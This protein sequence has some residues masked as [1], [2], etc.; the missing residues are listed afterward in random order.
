MQQKMVCTSITPSIGAEVSGLDCSNVDPDNKETLRQ[1]LISRKVLVFR[2]QIISALEFLEFMKIFGFPY[3]E[4]LEPQDGN[5]AEV[6]VIKIKPNERQIINFWHMDYS[7]LEKPASVL[8]LYAEKIP[9][10]GGDTL[11]TNLEAAYDSLGDDTKTEIDGLWTNH[12]LSVETQNAK[13]RWTKEELE[14]MDADA[15]IQHPLVCLNPDNNKKYLFVNVPIF[16]GSIVG[17]ENEKGDK[18]L[19]NLYHHAQRPEFSFRLTWS[20]N[21]MVVWENIHCLHYPVS[22]YFPHERKMLRVALKGERK[23]INRL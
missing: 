6:G 10:C 4:D 14:K 11:F 8:S 12:K 23:P 3:A 9:P 15:P 2:D 22:D 5:P 19:H 17:M 21:T 16:C 7:F 13:N 18:L 1:I 20:K